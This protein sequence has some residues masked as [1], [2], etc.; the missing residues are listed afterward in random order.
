VLLGEKL[1]VKLLLWFGTSV[2]GVVR[3]PMAKP[4]PLVLAAEMV[5]LTPPVLL[6]LTVWLLLPSRVRLPKETLAGFAVNRPGVTP[7][8]VSVTL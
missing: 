8:P 4:G 3:P 7:L 5:T 6:M 2:S 1:T